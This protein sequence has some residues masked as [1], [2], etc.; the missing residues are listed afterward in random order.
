[1][2]L[3]FA[4][5]YVDAMRCETG[6]GTVDWA[7]E[8]VKHIDELSNRKDGCIILTAHMGNYDIAAPMFASRFHRTLYAVRAPERVP[9]NQAL[10]EQEVREK[11]AKNPYFRTLFNREGNL[12]G[13]ELARL[14]S[15]GNIVAVQGDRVIFEVSPMIVE[16]EPGLKMQLPKGPLYLARVTDAPCYP[17]FIVR[18]GWRR[19][20]VIVSPPLVLPPRTRGGEDLGAKVWAEPIM[21][22]LRKHWSQWYVFE[23]MFTRDS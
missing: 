23:P 13:V 7:L 19:Y 3:N 1:M 21:D 12:L 11:E 4:L 8:G 16:V 5:T 18:D 6:T 17:L 10:R 2:F 22:I 9:E 15:E 20:R 14:L